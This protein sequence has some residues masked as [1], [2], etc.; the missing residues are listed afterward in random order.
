MSYDI[1][2]LVTYSYLDATFGATQVNH[3]VVG[4]RGKVGFVRDIEVDVAT[5]LVGTSTVPE[6]AVGTSQGDATYGRY[7][8]GTAVGTGYGVGVFKASNEL[9]VGNPPRVS[10]VFASKVILDGGPLVTSGISG[11]SFGTQVPQGRIPASGQV[12]TNVINGTS[13]VARVFLRDPIPPQVVVG[14]LVNVHDVQG[15]TFNIAT[16]NVT[17]SALSSSANNPANPNWIELTGTTFGGAYTAGGLVDYNVSISNKA[18][19]GGT[20]AGGGTVRVKIEWIGQW[21]P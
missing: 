13:N 17:I 7:R 4:P 5:A 16:S 2:E 21:A 1:S 11:G 14:Q 19:T 3:L 20:P 6:V 12:V 18:G 9:I 10:T 15:A 8:L